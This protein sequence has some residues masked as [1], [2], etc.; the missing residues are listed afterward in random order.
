MSSPTFDYGHVINRLKHYN[1]VT[2]LQPEEAISNVKEFQKHFGDYF[3]ELHLSGVLFEKY[4]QPSIKMVTTKSMH[5]DTFQFFINNKATPITQIHALDQLE[6]GKFYLIFIVGLDRE[7]VTTRI[8]MPIKIND[9]DFQ[10]FSVID[11][12]TYDGTF[13]N[14]I[15]KLPDEL[16]TVLKS[17][18]QVPNVEEI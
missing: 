16:N 12:C 6:I 9:T 3:D 1:I 11:R 10:Y 7:E 13:N 5:G 2:I 17:Y 18:Y 8:A 14:E 4:Y 15:V